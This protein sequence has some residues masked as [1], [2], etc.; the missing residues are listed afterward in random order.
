MASYLKQ[1]EELEKLKKKTEQIT[2]KL[3]TV[4]QTG[5]SSGAPSSSQKTGGKLTVID[6]VNLANEK[7]SRVYA[8]NAYDMSDNTP[9][10]IGPTQW[11]SPT[12]TK[13]ITFAPGTSISDRAAVAG[14]RASIAYQDAFKPTVKETK[15]NNNVIYPQQ[16]D[17]GTSNVMPYI[18]SDNILPSAFDTMMQNAKNME[19]P[20]APTA[21]R[22]GTNLYDR[23]YNAL[24]S[25]GDSRIGSDLSLKAT[26]KQSVENE[27]EYR[28]FLNENSGIID[29]LILAR[30]RYP[31]GSEEYKKYNSAI[32]KIYSGADSIRNTAADMTEANKFMENANTLREQATTGMGTVG[33]A[34]AEA[35]MSATDNFITMSMT[36]FNPVASTVLMGINAGGQRMNELS[37]KGVSAADAFGRGTMSAVIEAL[38]EKIGIDNLYDIVGSNNVKRL[39]SIL[40]QAASEGT[41]EGLGSILNYA[42]DRMAGD[43]ES[44]DWDDFSQSVIQGFL[45]GF[46]FG[47]GGNVVNAVMPKASGYSDMEHLNMAKGLESRQYNGILPKAGEYM[48]YAGSTNVNIGGMSADDYLA[49]A[50]YKGNEIIQKPINRNEVNSP[51]K[52]DMPETLREPILQN[53]SI[54]VSDATKKA[55]PVEIVGKI[56]E[57]YYR[58]AYN[59]IK[60]YAKGLGIFKQYENKNIDIKFNFSGES[61]NKSRSEQQTRK[62]NIY[63]FLLMVN[64]FD[65]I[66]SNAK[67]IEI[68]SDKINNGAL[69]NVR[70][71]ASAF[72]NG[73][74]VVPVEIEIKEYKQGRSVEP[75][76]Y[77]AVTINKE[78]KTVHGSST[79]MAAL[80]VNPP[81]SIRLTDLV[82]GVNGRNNDFLKYFPD[83]MLDETQKEYKRQAIVKEDNKYKAK[84]EKKANLAENKKSV[85]QTLDANAPSFTSK[86]PS[87][88]P[89]S[90]NSIPESTAKN[91]NNL[92]I[93]NPDVRELF[94]ATRQLKENSKSLHQS[95]ISGW[96]PFERMA[97]A[98]TRQNGRNITALAN[99]YGQ[100]GGTID[101]I[102][103]RGMYDI[104]GNKVDNRSY[105]E[106]ASQVPKAQKTDF[107]TYWHELHNI[108]RQAQGKPV[109]EHT[110]E[111]SKQIVA[112]MEKKYP[113]FKQYRQDIADYY[114]LFLR[115]WGVGSGLISQESYLAMKKMYPNYVPTFRVDDGV[116]GGGSVKSGKKIR[117]SNAI[118]RAKGSTAEVMSFDEA[119]AK[120]MSS[121]ITAATKN[122][123]S[124]EIFSFAQA[125]PAEAAQNGI[126]I[127]TDKSGQYSGQIDIDDYLDN[128]DKDIARQISKGN[129]EVTFYDN[130]KPQTMK[131]SRDVWEAYNFLDNKLGDTKA[132]K[133]AADLGRFFTNPMRAMTTTYNPLFF[134]TNLIRD[135]QT[136]TMNNTA[137][138][139]A[140]AMKN[141]VKAIKGIATRS[142]TYEQYR[143][144]GGSQNGYYGSNM[145]SQAEKRVNPGAKTFG[146]KAL[147]V[148]KSPLTAIEAAGEFTEKIPRYAEYLNTIDRYGN[149]DA[150]RMQASLNAADVTVNFNR[151]S[152]L[153]TLA[154]AW[155]P[156][157][158]AGLQGMDKTL[159]QIKA[160]PV[161]TTARATVSVFLPTLLLYMV[162]KDNPYWEDVKDGVRDNYYLIPNYAGPVTNGYA[163][164]FIRIPKSREF[165]ALF[166]ASFER[167]VRALNSDED[168]KL[169]AMPDAFDGYLDTLLN[170]FMPNSVLDDNIFGAMKRL[171]TNTAWH[172]GKIVPSNLV[173]V[174]PQ[175]QYDINTSGIAMNA[176]K[177]AER[178]AF[179]PD[180]AKSPM[181]VD[182]MIDSYGGYMGDLL[183]GLTSRKNIGADTME[184][185]KNSLYNGFIQ[186]VK[187]RFSTDSAYSN[188]N[189]DRFYDRTDEL[190]VAA[191][192]RNIE[193]NLPTEYVTPEEKIKSDFTKASGSITDLT[194]QERAILESAMPIQEKNAQI[195]ELKKQKNDIAKDMLT[196]EKSLFEEY[197]RNYVPQ[198]SKLSDE[199]QATAK[200]LV[201]E[202]GSRGFG[203]DDYMNIYEKYAELNKEDLTAREKATELEEFLAE[204]GYPR[205]VDITND[206]RNEFRFYSMAPADSYY[207]SKNYQMVQSFMPVDVYADLS[208]T[209]SKMESGVDY[210]KGERSPYYKSAIDQYLAEY[211]Y[212]PTYNQRMKI[213]ESMGV[214]KKYRY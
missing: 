127:D 3:K 180:W 190:E 130:G 82:K 51:I 32:D 128:I 135:A 179:A 166:S 154:N 24:S 89:L 123:I 41:E 15:T 119:I 167:F 129:Y 162:N 10:P 97:K 107:N 44:F 42:A 74:E 181:K 31:V 30:D 1:M 53:I 147:G 191:N 39:S 185:V 35:G 27:A 213:Y 148:L 92:G 103:T 136:Y 47:V 5:A 58:E 59:E 111:E 205:G 157:F 203:Y 71:L 20:A 124:R 104:N 212:N 80:P 83:S 40:K 138:N 6:K 54:N 106:V 65:N 184:T 79:E 29:A 28:K 46:M 56:N 112:D 171:G 194:K 197:A 52:M 188:Y 90:D 195:R 4:K 13:N 68:H 214:A 165:G 164:T 159:R 174:S 33:K 206:L 96:A 156:Y 210:P 193:D 69:K 64:D 142:E 23:T 21:V 43:K 109:T 45:S 186:P 18:K 175:N 132:V 8:Q 120:K 67:L 11:N 34:L 102:L 110:I 189:L 117:G 93:V 113:Q 95:T 60:N 94:E 177:T 134:L 211:G 84:N 152:T 2:E 25:I 200:E 198:I 151:S 19:M 81:S 196:N 72:W 141:Y 36:G 50:E 37:N 98:D 57:R 116:S 55:V 209:L 48:P 14:E 158:N 66:V 75:K 88:S 62:N 144:L 118:G 77:M 192:D 131:I 187:N 99:R 202:Y 161:Q 149:T 91:N 182:Y 85:T 38:T 86:T 207:D 22:N 169:E 204:E 137:K 201:S 61:Y 140:V 163:E 87:A 101:T 73:N 7:A 114:D 70:V 121:I 125:L 139:S 170:S 150:G 76:L 173:N 208:G 178:F 12:D 17:G 78:G 145:Y 168:D 49:N 160:H 115:T 26:A 16:W 133:F 176:A 172:G 143:S 122:D 9:K 199:R 146:Q 153:S 155:V 63:D 108:D 100:K 105:V 183:Q 126:L